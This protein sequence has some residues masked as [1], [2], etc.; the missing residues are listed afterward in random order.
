MIIRLRGHLG[1]TGDGEICLDISGV[2]Y[3]VF[4]PER[5]LAQLPPL[6]EEVIL[7]I[8]TYV[9]E[10]QLHLYG[11][12]TIGERELFKNLLSVSRIGPTA[13]LKILSSM[14]VEDF[15]QAILTEDVDTLKNIP[16]IGK[17][18]AQRMILELKNRLEEYSSPSL[19]QKQGIPQELIAGLV[20]LGY[21]PLEAR[22]AVARVKDQVP[23][24]DE[25]GILRLALKE[26]AKN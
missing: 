14:G 15:I 23:A 16:G 6:G 12:F 3:Q 4:L 19:E 1:A 22:E 8:Y 24:G 10:D 20:N 18:T 17:K 25:Q 26:L 21:T 7:N 13:A 5:S 11:F 2:G 9:R